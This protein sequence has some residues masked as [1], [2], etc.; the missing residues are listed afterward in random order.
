VAKLQSLIAADFARSSLQG[1]NPNVLALA[2]LFRLAFSEVV[3]SDQTTTGEKAAPVDRARAA[4][5]ASWW[6]PGEG[7][8]EIPRLDD[9]AAIGGVVWIDIRGDAD[10]TELLALLGRSCPGLEHEMLDELLDPDKEPVNRRWAGG[11]VRLA[12]T[13]AVYPGAEGNETDWGRKVSSS[14]RAL[15]QPVELLAGRDWLITRWHE[16]CLYRGSEP[17]GERKEAVGKREVVEAVKRRWLEAEG[18]GAGDLGVLVMHELALT[19]APAHRHFRASLEEW[20]LRLYGVETELGESDPEDDLDD[21][22][23]LWGARARLRDWLS[24]LNV[25]GLNVDPDK[26]WLPVR[27]HAEVKAID[28]RV[29]KSLDALATLGNTLRSSFHLLHIK[30]SEAHRER[31]ESMQRRVEYIAAGF[32]VPTLIVGFFGA[33]T[34]VPGEH[35]HWGL[36]LMVVSMAVLTCIVVA[37]LLATRRRSSSRR[38]A[39]LRRTLPVSR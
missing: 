14:P 1:A 8:H 2:D 9:V 6:V 11:A 22:K 7:P 4:I 26:A 5:D 15:Y 27:N 19:Y 12:S 35:R 10:A 21:L 36:M 23:A 17:D 18:G 29:D 16:A 33:N 39:E 3:A 37:V 34:W 30:M 38:S 24:P 25:A 31:H 13:F 28:K 32:L 20:E